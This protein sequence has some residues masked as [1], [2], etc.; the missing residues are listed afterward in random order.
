MSK[1]QKKN[2][3]TADLILH[4]SKSQNKKREMGLSNNFDCV[5]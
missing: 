5:G 2:K 3:K 1:W 4:H